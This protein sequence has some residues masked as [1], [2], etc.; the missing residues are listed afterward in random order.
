MNID[1]IFVTWRRIMFSLVVL[2]YLGFLGFINVMMFLP[3]N[4][5]S[6]MRHF[7]FF[8]TG[9]TH[10]LIHELVFAFIIGTA[11]VGLLSQLWKPKENFAGQLVALIVWAAMILTAAFTNN[12]VPQP[13]FIIFGGLTILATILHPAGRGLFNWFKV[14]KINRIPLALVI[15]ATIPLL[16]LAV[17]NINLQRAGTN[18]HQGENGGSLNL[19]GHKIPKHGSSEDK[20]ASTDIEGVKQQ[21]SNYTIEQAEREDYK[22]DKFCLDAKSFGQ[23]IERGAMG[24][25]ATNETLLRGPI[26]TN[27]PQA[28]MFDDKESVLGVEYE[29]V[30]DAVSEPPQLF[31]Q[32]FTKLPSH[33]GVI[34]EHYAL[35]V[36]FVDNPNGQFADFN[37][38]VSCPPSS[39]PPIGSGGVD[40]ND[41]VAHDQEHVT[42]GHYRNMTVLS[43]IIIL[44]GILASF[45]PKGWRLAAW[46]AGFLPI[47]LGL[48]SVVLPSAESSFGVAWGI[49]AITWGLI[50]IAVAEVIRHKG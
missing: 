31:G 17:T 37:S 5:M 27:R 6:A 2:S 39:T 30:A 28:L 1:K 3:N 4:W 18:I 42:M 50:F 43:F 41:E 40:T 44:V 19:F 11:A 20:M 46:I 29:I 14:G 36:W 33:P 8:Y 7:D 45:R 16:S 35:H 13:L 15:I 22:L 23:P 26:A 32:T 24:F 21:Y 47:L 9:E 10:N 25:H 48:S 38:N 12:W 34:H 49:A